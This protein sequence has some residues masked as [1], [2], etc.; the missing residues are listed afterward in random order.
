MGNFF[1]DFVDI[2]NLPKY[3]DFVVFNLYFTYLTIIVDEIFAY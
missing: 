1:V 2:C 3:I